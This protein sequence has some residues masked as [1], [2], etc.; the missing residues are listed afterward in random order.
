MDPETRGLEALGAAIAEAEAAF[1][2]RR[3]GVEHSAAKRRLLDALVRRPSVAPRL[4]AA[5]VGVALVVT[6]LVYAVRDRGRPESG[7]GPAAEPAAAEWLGAAAGAGR[8][9]PGRP[10]RGRRDGHH[11]RVG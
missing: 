3:A 11:A 4:A 6:L 10:R 1:L 7:P 5:I 2:E 9:R 8:P